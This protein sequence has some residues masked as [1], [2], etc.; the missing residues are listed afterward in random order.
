MVNR[1]V[2]K[3]LEAKKQ[4]L[5]MNLENNY[6]DLARDALKEYE[7]AVEELYQQRE[8]K[9]KDYVRYKTDVEMYKERMKGYHH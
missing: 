8:L 4:E 5:C 2:K 7:R 6:K 9:E 1:K 3:N